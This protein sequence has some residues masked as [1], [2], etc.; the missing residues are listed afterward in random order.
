MIAFFISLAGWWLAWIAG[1][2]ALI[3]LMIAC[4]VTFDKN[5]WLVVGI[6][7][8]IAAFGEL[9]VAVTLVDSNMYCSGN[10]NG[11][12]AISQAGS[13][14]LSIIALVMWAIVSFITINQFRNGGEAGSTA[15]D[16]PT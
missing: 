8:A 10:A 6:S 12:C 16:L 14:I 7:S 1:V 3:I 2:I 13:I 9:L 15:N 5:I 11:D 4:C